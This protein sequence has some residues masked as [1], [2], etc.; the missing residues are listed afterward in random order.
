L[1]EGQI[2]IKRSTVAVIIIL[3]LVIG[4]IV[5]QV[6]YAAPRKPT[7]YKYTTGLT[8]KFKVY[9]AGIFSLVTSDATIG[10][11]AAGVDPL[12]SRTFTTKPVATA[13][14]DSVLA[15]W[16]VPLD[17]GSYVAFVQEGTTKVWYPESYTVTVYGT[18]NEDREVWLN[19]S[20][21]NVYSRATPGLGHA[22]KAYNAT[23]GAYDIT[24]TTINYTAYDKWFVT[25]SITVSDADTAK[26]I[27]AGRLYLTKITGLDPT[28][29]SVDGTVTA[30]N[31]DTDASDDGLTGYY[32][33]FP[34]MEVGEVH[35]VDVYFED[36]GASAGTM[37]AKLW[38]YYACLRT[39]TVIRWWTLKTDAITVEA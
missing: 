24:Q 20:Q 11:Y 3:A 36:T 5:W 13:S 7:A 9:D 21:L 28:S 10:F 16:T 2:T 39:G 29:A 25:Y 33:E 23:S 4:L 18:D 35:R 30:V 27:K 14:Y 37:T 22:I 17:A 6:Y 31:D 38:E 26:I 8:V 1:P 32:V 34:L 12:G 19:P 15:A